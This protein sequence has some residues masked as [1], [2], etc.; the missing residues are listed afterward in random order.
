MSAKTRNTKLKYLQ[1]AA[2]ALMLLYGCAGTRQVQLEKSELP[3]LID[4]LYQADQSTALI[5]PPDSAA[6]AYQRTIRSNFPLVNRI[7]KQFGYPGY[8]LLG[9]ETSDKYFLLVQHADF[10]TAFQQAV[11]KEIKKHVERKNASGISFAF[12]TDRVEISAGRPQVYGT[13]VNMGRN[14]TIKPCIDTLNL[15]NR[16]KSV[17]LNT[18]KEYLEQCNEAFYQMNPGERPKKNE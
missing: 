1:A 9:R 13:Q 15:D 16:R 18:I 11:L 5:R 12:L 3:R 14:T 10:D 8:D 17:G 4:S 7:F 2:L 6:A